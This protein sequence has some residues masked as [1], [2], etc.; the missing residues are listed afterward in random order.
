MAIVI[1]MI[2]TGTNDVFGSKIL[3]PAHARTLIR[4]EA[5]FQKQIG[6]KEYT[7]NFYCQME[8]FQV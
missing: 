6:H 3:R 2:C 7:L 5:D 1:I 8:I 4:I